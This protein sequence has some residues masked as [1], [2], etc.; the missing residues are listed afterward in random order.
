MLLYNYK[1][2]EW[3]DP[4]GDKDIRR[5]SDAELIVMQVIWTFSTALSGSR[6]VAEVQKSE[7]WA[8]TTISTLVTRL[9]D[10]GFLMTT[11]QGRKR[12][13]APLID[14]QQYLRYATSG[15]LSRHYENSLSDLISTFA[16]GRLSQ[17]ELEELEK[18]VSKLEG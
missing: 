10:K 17:E 14:K 7:D 15:F 13:Y 11:K 8:D 4:L 9:V 12:Y 2:R 1:C 5:L 16:N 3:D 6:I 18:I